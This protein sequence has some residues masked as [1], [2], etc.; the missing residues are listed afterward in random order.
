MSIN[1]FSLPVDIPWKKVC[2]SEDMIDPKVCDRDF[3]LRWRSS[4]A[5]FSHEPS[6]DYQIHEGMKLT[7]LK[8]VATI[9]GFQPEPEEVGIKDRSVDVSWSDPAVIKNYKEIVNNFYGCYGAILEV[10]VGPGKQDPDVKLKDFPYF[11]DFAPKKRE[12]YETVSATGEM[13]SRSLENVNVRK[14]TTSAGSHEMLDVFGGAEVSAAAAGGAGGGAGFD[15][16][17]GSKDMNQQQYSNI[18]TSDQAREMRESFSHTTHLT[19]MYHELTSYHLGTNRSVFFMLPR[20]HIIDSESTFTNGPRRLEGIQEFFLVVL[21]PESVKELCMEAYLETAHVVSE[22]QFEYETKTDTLELVVIARCQDPSGSWGNDSQTFVADGSETYHVPEGWEVD[23][24]R[25]GGA[26]IASQSGDRINEVRITERERDHITLWGQCT[27]RFYDRQWPETNYCEQGRI[28]AQATI[29]LRKKA[30][31]ISGY[32]QNL[33]LTGRGICCCK[34]QSQMSAFSKPHITWE[35]KMDSELTKKVGKNGKI[36]TQDAN[37]LRAEIGRL[38]VQS[39]NDPDRYEAG[40][41]QFVD[42]QFLGRIMGSLIQEDGHADNQ[43]VANLKNISNSLLGKVAKGASRNVSRRKILTTSIEEL[44]DRFNMTHEE[45]VKLRR[46]ALG[47]SGPAPKGADRWKSPDE[48][49]KKTKP[50]KTRKTISR[51]NRQKK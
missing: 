17:W 34:T 49:N 6:E 2:V 3:P 13:M 26:E 20:P 18:R 12:I 40:N 36:S 51:S 23:L 50:R 15:G 46:T 8:V 11:A 22:P 9:T 44:K 48:R 21:R 38:I 37:T 42:T 7:Y 32:S 28:N 5:V 33:W 47:L 30:P 35:K 31:T 4:L 45:A 27:A 1:S 16:Q 29:Y 14:G 39:K 43:I 19:Q 10:S 41:I 24:D 25:N